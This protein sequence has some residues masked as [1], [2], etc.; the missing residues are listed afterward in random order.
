MNILVCLKMVSQARFTD[1][2]R[3]SR[4]DRL[5]GGQLV[6]NPAD[7]YA[8]ELA[9][10]LKDRRNDIF[11]TVLTMAPQYADHILR[12]ALA[13]GA[14]KAVHICDKAF[15]GSDTIMTAETISRA[16]KKLP[17]Q[18]MI[19][20]GKKAID[21][22]TGHIGPQLGVA[23]G[24]PWVT[25]VTDIS[26]G[27]DSDIELVRS[28][29]S[30]VVGLKLKGRAVLTVCNGTGMVRAPGIIGLRRSREQPI[31]LWDRHAL[32]IEDAQAGTNGSGT[33]TVS[34]T[35]TKFRNRPNK[36]YCSVREGTAQ[37][38]SLIKEACSHE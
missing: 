17:P 37:I 30:S 18:D 25:N 9:L 36:T 20:C 2:L 6:M 32:G 21:S 12:T 28:Q 35:E 15:A 7:S 3:D 26:F 5:S 8:L 23:L 4:T 11:I 16:I 1:S 14:D 34:V 38:C 29:E 13:M 10:R 22:E 33:Q 24:I 19:L 31:E 27:E